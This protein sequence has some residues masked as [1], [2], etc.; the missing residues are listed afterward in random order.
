[1]KP[2]TAEILGILNERGDWKQLLLWLAGIIVLSLVFIYL[3]LTNWAYFSVYMVFS[4]AFTGLPHEPLIMYYGK[5]YGIAGTTAW[6][7]MPTIVG[8]YLDYTVLYPLLN[9]QW[10]QK[11][12]TSTAYRKAEHFFQLAPFMTVALAALS[13]VPF[14]PIRL[15]SIAASYPAAQYTVAVLVGRLPRFVFLAAGGRF[16]GIPDHVLIWA[17][18]LMFILYIILIVRELKEPVK[19]GINS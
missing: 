19:T 14:F 4:T 15:L 6:T 13:P 18:I 5:H 16:L 17:S 3:D 7:I 1:M 10:I 2:T 8:C 9:S 12:K 11:V